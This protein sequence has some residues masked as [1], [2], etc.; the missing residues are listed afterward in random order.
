MVHYEESGVDNKE[1][2][3][4]SYNL[5]VR[6]L[7]NILSS[8]KKRLF[9]KRMEPPVGIEPTTADYKSAALPTELRWRQ[10]S[11]LKKLLKMQSDCAEKEK[12][13]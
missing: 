11:K 3:I 8:R 10:Y 4:H 7:I 9:L 12:L 13:S 5:M 1:G 2:L 6:K